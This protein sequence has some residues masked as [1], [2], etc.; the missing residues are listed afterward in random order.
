[1]LCQSACPVKNLPLPGEPV[2]SIPSV[3]GTVVTLVS[4]LYKQDKLRMSIWRFA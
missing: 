4:G 3:S 1:M 2:K